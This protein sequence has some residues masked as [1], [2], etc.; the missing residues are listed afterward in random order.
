[1]SW[2]WEV[3]QL[4]TLITMALLPQAARLAMF[5]GSVMALIINICSKRPDVMMAI[6]TLL[7]EN[8]LDFFDWAFKN[9]NKMA[10][11]LDYVPL[12]DAVI[13]TIQKLWKSEITTADGVTLWK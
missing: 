13:A 7:Q 2:L 1:M 5:I 9:G 12:P 4:V 8:V 6:I 3:P 11:D 10:E